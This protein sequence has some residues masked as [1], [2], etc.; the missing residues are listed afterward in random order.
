VALRRLLYSEQRVRMMF[1]RMKADLADQHA[2]HLSEHAALR[3]ELDALR[4][5]YEA[6]RCAVL[7][8]MKAEADLALLQRDRERL[9]GRAT[10]LH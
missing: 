4:G 6:L 8:R 7:E 1:A 2:R 9:E 10:W 3:R 5:E